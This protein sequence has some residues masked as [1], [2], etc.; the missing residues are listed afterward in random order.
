MCT[1]F[2]KNSARIEIIVEKLKFFIH[3][4]KIKN[5]GM[6]KYTLILLAAASLA[7]TSCGA[8]TSAETVT[9]SDVE[10]TNKMMNNLLQQGIQE[11]SQ[12]LADSTSMLNNALDTLK[13]V[14]GDNKELIDE[15]LEE[16]INALNKSL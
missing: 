3:L 8:E 6:K 15:K 11:A 5:R 1:K 14:I 2:S 4:I 10:N 9:P 16:G 13:N 7:I 12:Q